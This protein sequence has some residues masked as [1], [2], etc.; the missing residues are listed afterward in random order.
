MQNKN[1]TVYIKVTGR[2]QGVGFRYFVREKALAYHLNGWVRNRPDKRVEIEVQGNSDTIDVFIDFLK[3]G[4]GYS[5]V[6]KIDL[7]EIKSTQKFESFLI[8]Y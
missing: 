8:R 7:T 3:L 5:Q 6:D 4:N 1:K 2:V